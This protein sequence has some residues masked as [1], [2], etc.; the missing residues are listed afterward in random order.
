MKGLSSIYQQD[1]RNKARAGPTGGG[2]TFSL[3]SNLRVA[4]NYSGNR[5]VQ[6]V[7]NKILAMNNDVSNYMAMDAGSYQEGYQEG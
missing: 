1:L 3:K 7:G 5:S 4:N 6:G 2:S